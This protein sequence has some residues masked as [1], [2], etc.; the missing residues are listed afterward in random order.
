VIE[1]VPAERL[2]KR[3]ENVDLAVVALDDGS[4]W[5]G[6]ILRSRRP[7]LF[8]TFK[9]RKRRVCF[10]PRGLYAAMRFPQFLERARSWQ[11]RGIAGGV[12]V[13]DPEGLG[14]IFLDV[15][16]GTPPA[17]P[18]ANDEEP[19]SSDEEPASSPA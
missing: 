4:C 8:R 16:P 15:R 5:I 7:V 9:G 14:R 2:M 17:G 10:R 11:L 6:T 1:L 18:D 12:I 19:D 13:P 3:I